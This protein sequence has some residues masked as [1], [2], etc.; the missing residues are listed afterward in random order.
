V[1][2]ARL[3]AKSDRELQVAVRH[4]G[5]QRRLYYRSQ[6]PL[7]RDEP[8]T[9]DFI[10]VALAQFAAA[11]GDDLVVDGPVTRSQLEHL[12][13]MLQIWPVWRPRKF[14]RV[15]VRA[16]DEVELPEPGDRA[17]AAMGFSGGVDASFALAAHHDQLL[18]RLTRRIDLGVLVVG[19]DLRH[20][21]DDAVHRAT[22]SA[23]E[24]LTAYGVTPAVVSTNW[25]QE[26]CPAWF[27]M[28]NAG[29]T[30]ILHTL[31]TQYSCAV[32]ATDVDYRQELVR[33]PWSSNVA[34]NHLLGN[35]WFPVISTGG[36]HRRLDRVRH[37][38]QHPQLLDNLRVCYQTDA[39]GANCGICEKCVR[40]Q[41]EL[42]VVGVHRPAAFAAPLTL[43]RVLA[44]HAKRLPVLHHLEVIASATP[45]DDPWKP[46]LERW[47]ERERLELDRS[48]GGPLT[49]LADL[50]REVAALH[51]QLGAAQQEIDAVHRSHSWQVTRPLRAAGSLVEHARGRR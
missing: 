15:S 11:V 45:D 46:E 1:I 40:T 49:E 23:R 13:E 51:T 41:L 22:R 18:G 47:V 44:T 19:W 33:G 27:L 30:A 21:D 8:R 10:A 2:H 48:A 39:G 24:S 16:T 9:H 3:V 37:L 26:F 34:V 42:R 36:T 29:L 31:S 38:T 32:H 50:R 14:Q 12:D 17:G 35:P 5:A 25:Q 4:D 28:F 20:G 6:E 43:E 7:W